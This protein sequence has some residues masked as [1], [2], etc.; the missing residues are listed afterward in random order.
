MPAGRPPNPKALSSHVWGLGRMGALLRAKDPP[1][2]FLPAEVETEDW[3][4]EEARPQQALQ[5]RGAPTLCQCRVGQAHDAIKLQLEEIGTRLVLTEAKLLVGDLDTLDLKGTQG[6]EG[7]KYN[8]THLPITLLHKD[9]RGSLVH[10]FLTPAPC[11]LDTS[12]K[13]QVFSQVAFPGCYRSA[14]TSIFFPLPRPPGFKLLN[15]RTRSSPSSGCAQHGLDDCM[16]GH[17]GY[18]LPGLKH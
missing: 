18:P 7:D 2:G 8:S 15:R 16:K 13:G 9:P 6:M 12:C 17:L 14:P 4:G 1:S 10:P 5:G 3:A 11:L